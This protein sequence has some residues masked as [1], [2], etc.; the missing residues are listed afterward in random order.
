MTMFVQIFVLACACATGLAQAPYLA[1]DEVIG[2]TW[3][4]LIENVLSM[5]GNIPQLNDPRRHYAQIINVINKA[6][7]ERSGCLLIDYD[8]HY[9]KI[10]NGSLAQGLANTQEVV[11]EIKGLIADLQNIT[12]E[13]A[14]IVRDGVKTGGEHADQLISEGII[15]KGNLTDQNNMYVAIGEAAIA[16]YKINPFLLKASKDY[17]TTTFAVQ[18]KEYI[19]KD[20][21][22]KT[23]AVYRNYNY[24]KRQHSC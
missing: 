5:D 1:Y 16:L 11:T 9:P 21:I 7:S 12:K 20:A 17:T 15:L 10:V 18:D 6:G 13:V 8:S 19:L 22:D 24:Y 23:A 2:E 3:A 14:E 4:T